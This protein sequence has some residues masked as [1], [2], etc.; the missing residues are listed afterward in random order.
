MITQSNSILHYL[1]KK[2]PYKQHKS[3]AKCL[4]YEFRLSYSFLTYY[5]S[6]YAVFYL[7]GCHFLITENEDN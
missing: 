4:G 3:I 6:D 1:R 2:K 5:T 7:S